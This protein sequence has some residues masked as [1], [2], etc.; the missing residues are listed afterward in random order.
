MDDDTSTTPRANA[1]G[2]VPPAQD[3]EEKVCPICGAFVRSGAR[4]CK[5]CGQRFLVD[6]D[7]SHRIHP[8][9]ALP[10]A[11]ARSRGNWR[12][13]LIVGVCG[14]LVFALIGSLIVIYIESQPSELDNLHRLVQMPQSSSPDLMTIR[15]M[16]LQKV[17][18]G[19]PESGVYAFLQQSGAQVERISIA[20]RDRQIDCHP[21]YMDS[22]AEGPDIDCL[23]HRGRPE[24][25]CGEHF[26]LVTFI[27]DPYLKILKDITI[28]E[29]DVCALP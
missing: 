14:C 9:P 23:I 27:I 7:D 10:S 16:L 1:S 21:K 28:D 24:L 20:S 4:K 22:G 5:Y 3:G 15:T 26:Y 19:T 11:R 29:H 25:R 2:A 13:Y 6:D 12:S 8:T 17:P 18:V